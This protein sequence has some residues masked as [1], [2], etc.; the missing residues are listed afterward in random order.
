MRKL[1][2]FGS[3]GQARELAD[4]AH[5]LGYKDIFFIDFNDSIDNISGREIIPEDEIQKYRIN[6]FIIGIGEGSIRK[7]IFNKFS[8][9]NFINLIHPAATFEEGSEQIL[10]NTKGNIFCAGVRVTN[11]VE[12]GDFNLFNINS[13][14]SH[15]C[16]IEDFVT[17]SP[18]VNIAGNVH[19]FSEVFVGIGA[20]IS[21][22]KSIDNKLKIAEKAIVG[23]GAVVVKD[24]EANTIVKG[25][26]AK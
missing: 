6:D 8:A 4:L 1:G 16:I 9:L 22:G 15:D 3:S 25:I 17:L 5:L 7:K 2:V 14:V 26:P 13:T 11:N 10:M 12:I 23:A 20:T 21:N 24:V 19:I 18:G